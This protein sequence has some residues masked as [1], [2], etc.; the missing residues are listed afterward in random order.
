M[1]DLLHCFFDRVLELFAEHEKDE[2]EEEDDDDGESFG[3]HEALLETALVV[4]AR[5]PFV[6]G[7]PE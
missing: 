6:F 7:P 3:P 2:G 5:T 1:P 4:M